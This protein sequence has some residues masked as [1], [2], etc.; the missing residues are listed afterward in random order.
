MQCRLKLSLATVTICHAHVV[1][2][3]VQDPEIEHPL[4]ETLLL[5]FS[6]SLWHVR[7]AAMGLAAGWA[8]VLP[9]LPDYYHRCY[10]D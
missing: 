7:I 1:F 10:V 5:I 2:M 8:L 9:F 3:D 6:T 4:P